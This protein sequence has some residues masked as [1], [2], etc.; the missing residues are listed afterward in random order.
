MQRCAETDPMFTVADQKCDRLGQPIRSNGGDAKFAQRAQQIPPGSGV[1]ARLAG[2][3]VTGTVPHTEL[4]CS[5][6]G[7]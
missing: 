7:D 2:A 3:E 4:V 1:V 5:K 6:D